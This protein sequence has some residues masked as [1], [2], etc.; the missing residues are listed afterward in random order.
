[1][2]GRI[3]KSIFYLYIFNTNPKE[4]VNI[5]KNSLHTTKGHSFGEAVQVTDAKWLECTSKYMNCNTS[6]E[7]AI[8]NKDSFNKK[9]TNG[10]YKKNVAKSSLKE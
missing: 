10:K 7:T 1:M 4:S 9:I 6:M 8:L 2:I 5:W 3:Q